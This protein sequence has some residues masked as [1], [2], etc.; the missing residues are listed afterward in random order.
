MSIDSKN[1]SPYDRRVQLV[2]ATIKEN[3]KLGNK[4]AMNLAVKVLHTLDHIPEKVR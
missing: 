1:V 4:A 2:L 3:E